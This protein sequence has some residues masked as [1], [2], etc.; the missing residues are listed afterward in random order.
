MR[1]T[2]KTLLGNFTFSKSNYDWFLLG[3]VLFLTIFGLAFLASSLAPKKL[4][5]FHYNLLYQMIFG[6]WIGGV[7]MYILARTD[8]HNLFKHSRIFIVI[9]LIFLTFLGVVAG[10]AQFLHLSGQDLVDHAA[11]FDNPIL[12][13]FIANGAIRWVKTPIMVVQASEFAKLALLIY[14]A[15]HLH[16]LS[17]RKE[18]EITWYDM[19]KPLYT[20]GLCAGLIIVQPDLGSILLIYTILAS[21][22]F[23]GKVP[24]KIITIITTCMIGFGLFFALGTGYRRERVKSVFQRNTDSSYQIDG[25]E[26]AIKNGGLFG[27]GYGNSQAKQQHTILE[28]S[29][30]SIIGVISEEIG[31]IGTLIFLAMYLLLLFRGMKIADEAKDIGGKT[32]AVGISVW[33]VTQAFLNI[34]GN[35]G[36]VPLKGLPLPFVSEGGSA[37]VLNLMSMGMILNVSAQ[38]LKKSRENQEKFKKMRFNNK[39][40]GMDKVMMKKRPHISET[41]EL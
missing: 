4:E 35:L 13:P 34:G 30:D 27:K 14:F 28:S 26:K 22:M 36:I 11:K 41:V 15:G 6:V 18:K 5:E 21:M 32:L 1:T 39:V 33:V 37:I 29:T 8:Y 12:S 10:S 19:K 17:E 24:M 7:M 38:G 2:P 25:V 16:K 23:A 20:F 31:F 3:I 40:S 9:N